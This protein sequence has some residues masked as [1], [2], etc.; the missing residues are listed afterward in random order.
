[1]SRQKL[2]LWVV[3]AIGLALA[4]ATLRAARR[5]TSCGPAVSPMPAALPQAERP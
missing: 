5:A 4:Y 3:W 1:M 2:R